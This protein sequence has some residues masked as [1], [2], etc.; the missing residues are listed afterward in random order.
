MGRHTE[1]YILKCRRCGRIFEGNKEIYVEIERDNHQKYCE[2][3]K[4]HKVMK[5]ILFPFAMLGLVLVMCG[6]I[7]YL[8][9]AP[10]AYPF[11]Y[12]MNLF[13]G[14]DVTNWEEY[15]EKIYSS[16]DDVKS[17]MPKFK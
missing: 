4:I 2:L 10:V 7:I 14:N 6:M 3:A 8:A 13:L 11:I 9:F 12:A 15:K 16:D 17:R 1:L 5:V